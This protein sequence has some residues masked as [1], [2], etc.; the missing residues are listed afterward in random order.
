MKEKA[1]MLN[2]SLLAEF[3]I[4]VLSAVTRFQSQPRSIR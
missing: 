3:Q 4:F 2:R 1:E